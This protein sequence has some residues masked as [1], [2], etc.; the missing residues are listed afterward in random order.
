MRRLEEAGALT[1]RPVGNS[2]RCDI[3]REARV[4]SLLPGRTVGEFL[5]ALLP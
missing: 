5:D 3:H 2:T 1:R 4:G